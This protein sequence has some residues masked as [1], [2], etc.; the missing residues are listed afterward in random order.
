M[1]TY[2]KHFVKDRTVTLT[3]F[4]VNFNVTCLHVMLC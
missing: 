2:T 4:K 3:V 1:Y